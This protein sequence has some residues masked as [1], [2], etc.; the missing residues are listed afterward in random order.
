MNTRSSLKPWDERIGP[1]ASITKLRKGKLLSSRTGEKLVSQLPL[2]PPGSKFLVDMPKECPRDV[3]SAVNT[4]LT[5][6]RAYRS[7]INGDDSRIEGKKM[8]NSHIQPVAKIQDQLRVGLRDRLRMQEI[9][10]L[11]LREEHERERQKVLER[12]QKRGQMQ[13]EIWREKAKVKGFDGLTKP[14]LK[15]PD[16]PH[17]AAAIKRVSLPKLNSNDVDG[18]NNQNQTTNPDD[19]TTGKQLDPKMLYRT[20]GKKMCFDHASSGDHGPLFGGTKEG[21]TDASHKRWSS[22]TFT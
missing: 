9:K 8:V 6:W 15:Q 12:Q 2:P 16:Q 21:F 11:Q 1:D 13:D 19:T 20:G 17:A 5:I 10:E 14:V 4:D 7:V 18:N 3:T 22:K